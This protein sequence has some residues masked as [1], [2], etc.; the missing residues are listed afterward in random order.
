MRLWLSVSLPLR[1]EGEPTDLQLDCIHRKAPNSIHSHSARRGW[2]AA[3]GRAWTDE[4]YRSNAPSLP[5]I[6]RVTTYIDACRLHLVSFM[7]RQG[8]GPDT[9]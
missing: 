9:V 1:V 7:V 8:T 2:L 4:L 5:I 3:S 6:S